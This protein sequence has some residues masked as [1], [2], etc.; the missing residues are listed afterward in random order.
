MRHWFL[1]SCLI[2]IVSCSKE[3]TNPIVYE[4]LGPTYVSH[5]YKDKLTTAQLISRI[6]AFIPNADSFIHPKYD[7][8]AYRIFYK[9]HDYQNNEITASGLV[10]VPEIKNYYLPV[11]LYQHGTA[12]QKQEVPS[13]A[14]DMGYYVPFIMASE[15]G[16]LVCASDYIGLG[17]SDGVQHFYEPSEEANAVVDMLGSVQLLLNKT[18]RQLTFDYDVFLIGYSQGGHA[19]LA[20]QRKLETKYPYQFHLKASAPMAGWFSLEKSTQFSIMKDSLDYSFSSAYAFLIHSIQTT[21]QIYPTY[22][23][24]FIPPYDSLTNVLFNGTY[25]TGAVGA[26]FPDFFYTVLQPAFRNDLKNNPNNIFLNAAKK[27]DVIND[28]IPKT[29]TRFYHSKSDEIAFYDNSEIAFNTFKS[30]SGNVELINLGNYSHFEGNIIAIE[31]VRDWFYPL[32]KIS[33]Y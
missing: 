1:L 24:V 3:K 10:F 25:S 7:V 8:T 17:F 19:T 32:I 12:I 16:T 2:I 26:Q 4:Q 15:T 13:I 28:W 18:Y 29:P 31:K 30:K 11:V 9:T 27:Y 14:A 22:T 23:S 6:N 33:A 21:Q 5:R 20:A